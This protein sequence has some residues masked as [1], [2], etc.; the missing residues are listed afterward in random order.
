MAGMKQKQRAKPGKRPDKRGEILDTAADYFLAHGYDGTS[1]NEMAR[2]SGISK[3]SIYRYFRSK[4]RLFAAV[5]D[6]ELEDYQ[7]RLRAVSNARTGSLRKQLIGVA[8]TLLGVVTTDRTLGLRR[9]IFQQASHNREVGRHYF[10][11]GPKQAYSHLNSLFS[12]HSA[13]TGFSPAA[14]SQHF[15]ALVLHF[16]LLQRECAIRPPF[17]ASQI[18]EIAARAV[19]AFMRTFLRANGRS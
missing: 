3:E 5:I 1:I 10:Q 11:T 9:L 15:L 4:K 18:R 14:L 8:E 17:R 19:D 6:R 12:A 13:R 2:E 7:T 16:P